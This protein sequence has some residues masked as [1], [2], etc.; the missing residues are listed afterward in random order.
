MC[1]GLER[2]LL[3]ITVAQMHHIKLAQR[4][5][6]LVSVRLRMDSGN[7]L[8]LTFLTDRE[9]GNYVHLGDVRC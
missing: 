7:T 6:G 2:N 4:P 5:V 3:Q 8:Q 9:R 1:P